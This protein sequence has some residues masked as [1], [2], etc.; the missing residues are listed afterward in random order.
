MTKSTRES[1][2]RLSE[3]IGFGEA[4]RTSSEAVLPNLELVL[5]QPRVAPGETLNFEVRFSWPGPGDVR[6]V[7]LL[8][9]LA[10][11]DR[12]FARATETA[13]GTSISEQQEWI[14]P[15]KLQIP[16]DGT[17]GS[18][19]LSARV[20]LEGGAVFISQASVEVG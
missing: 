16:G 6:L 5:T 3:T 17:P 12:N 20:L 15:V 7:E 4:R 19:Q 2:T 14:V 8:V 10:G 13:H 18:W 1:K 11:E 9:H